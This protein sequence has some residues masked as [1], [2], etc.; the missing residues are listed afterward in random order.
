MLANNAHTTNETN[1]TS[2]VEC[3]KCGMSFLNANLLELHKEKFCLGPQQNY[4]NNTNNRVGSPPI[5]SKFIQQQQQFVS[6]RQPL[7]R[8]SFGSDNNITSNN[9]NSNKA[10]STINQLKSYKNK[11]SIEQSL[12]DM[13]D[14]LIRDTIRDKKIATSF[15]SPVPQ[16]P[17]TA[18]YIISNPN[19]LGRTS[20]FS[21]NQNLNNDP[22]RE[23]LKEVNLINCVN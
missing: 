3:D 16:A 17:P 4:S 15:N 1:T 10:Q 21:Q 20:I 12:K 14:T 19:Q 5:Q 2:S 8:I 22:F 11:K 13:E 23:L 18:P 6:P 7:S 9:F